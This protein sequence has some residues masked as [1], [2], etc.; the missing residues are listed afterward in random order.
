MDTAPFAP[1]AMRMLLLSN[2]RDPSG[3]YLV[4]ARSAWSEIARGCRTALFF[5]FAGTT[6]GWDD[7]LALVREA[8]AA[9]QLDIRGAH[10]CDAPATAVAQADLLLVG[11]GN[12]FRLLHELRRRGW[13]API[14]HAVCNGKPYVGWSAGT[15]VAT[16]SIAT[17]NDMPI[18]DPGGL[19]ALGVFPLQVNAHYHD[20][21]PPG[22][23]GESR[24]QRI[25]EYLVL[26]PGATVLGLPEGN[27]IE[28][29]DGQCHLCGPHPTWLFRSGID[30]VALGQGLLPAA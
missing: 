10:H 8:L 16:P 22:H 27:W 7:Y 6:M 21:L 30:P 5:P 4:H 18:I 26:H 2:S 11:G 20:A 17:T 9:L 24:R 1:P 12:T 3:N 25:A 19:E 15:V 13:L 14:R 29:R 23:Q 28:V